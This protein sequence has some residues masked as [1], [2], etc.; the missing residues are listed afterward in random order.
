MTKHRKKFD[1]RMNAI[2]KQMRTLSANNDS[3]GKQATRVR[4]K[5][6]RI[7]AKIRNSESKGLSLKTESEHLTII[8]DAISTLNWVVINNN[9]MF[10]QTRLAIVNFELVASMAAPEQYDA[11]QLEQIVELVVGFTTSTALGT[12][13]PLLG[14]AAGT[15]ILIRGIQ[16]IKDQESKYKKRRISDQEVEKYEK[17]IYGNLM[18]ATSSFD[19]GFKNSGEMLDKCQ[20][21]LSGMEES[22][23]GM[24]NRINTLRI[25]K[26]QRG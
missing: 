10:T 25:Q 26:K 5:S 18:T 17:K 8:R 21:M 11:K 22:L 7:G 12:I 16:E 3:V 4:N 14:F 9:L 6:Y 23:D 24:R 1:Q 13:N 20:E 2:R 15:A 19:S